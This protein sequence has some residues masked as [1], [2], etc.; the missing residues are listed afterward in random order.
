M[1]Q[2]IQS[3]KRCT[4]YAASRSSR[5]ELLAQIETAQAAVLRNVRT[6]SGPGPF[7]DL[8][9]E[10][11]RPVFQRTGLMRLA[12]ALT[13]ERRPFDCVVVR[14][15]HCLAE[16]V[17]SIKR[18]YKALDSWRVSIFEAE[19]ELELRGRGGL[20]LLNLFCIMEEAAEYDSH[21]DSEISGLMLRP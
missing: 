16:R 1:P 19:S 5:A 14:D 21:E 7:T 12:A 11:R 6:L 4:I 15:I 13:S 10:A 8:G 9:I 18:I 3:P 17:S 20:M 2:R